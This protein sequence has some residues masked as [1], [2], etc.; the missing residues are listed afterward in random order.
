MALSSLICADVPLRNCLLTH[1]TTCF[2]FSALTLSFECLQEQYLTFTFLPFPLGW[3]TS[4][5]EAV[6]QLL[7]NAPARAVS[8]SESTA[9][10]S[11][12]TV[13]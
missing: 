12:M 6:H 3:T 2:T 13:M 4:S 7:P 10:A 9:S 1:Y 5:A 8:T 11:H